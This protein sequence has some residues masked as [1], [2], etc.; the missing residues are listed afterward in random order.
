MNRVEVDV[1]RHVA[2]NLNLRPL[3]RRLA[4]AYAVRLEAEEILA[5][6]PIDPNWGRHQAELLR[7]FYTDAPRCVVTGCSSRH[8]YRIGL[9]RFHYAQILPGA[10][11]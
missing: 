5:N 6:L 8:I 9:C 10:Q 3:A 11:S 7:N 2:K 4:D 1:A